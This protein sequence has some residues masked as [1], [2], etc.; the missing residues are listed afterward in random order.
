MEE[1]KREEWKGTRK[2]GGKIGRK[3]DVREHRILV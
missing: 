3:E 1:G 2:K